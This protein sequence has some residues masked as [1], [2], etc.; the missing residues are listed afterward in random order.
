MSCLRSLEAALVFCRQP[1]RAL[2]PPPPLFDLPEGALAFASALGALWAGAHSDR[3]SISR[4]AI[5]GH[6][7]ATR[8]PDRSLQ[9]PLL[10][11][12]ILIIGR[13]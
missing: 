12:Q 4:P 8:S 10:E 1:A 3:G 11:L 6:S 7:E 5:S 13:S 9:L 2:L